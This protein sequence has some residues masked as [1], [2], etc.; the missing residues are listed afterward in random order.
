MSVEELEILAEEIRGAILKRC[1]LIGGQ[2]GSNL[3]MVEATLALN[4]FFLRLR[5]SV[6]NFCLTK[7]I[8]SYIAHLIQ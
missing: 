3:G 8:L 4:R 1:S 6:L 7:N 2:V 5:V